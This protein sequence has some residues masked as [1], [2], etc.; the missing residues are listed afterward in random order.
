MSADTYRSRFNAAVWKEYRK[1]WSGYRRLVTFFGLLGTAVPQ[2]QRGTHSVAEAMKGG[3]IGLFLSVLGTYLYSRRKGAEAL[4]AEHLQRI[5]ELEKT[6]IELRA[7][8]EAAK[9]NP[10]AE[11]LYQETKLHV[12]KL[13]DDGR[14]VLKCLLLHDTLA[15]GSYNPPIELPLPPERFQEILR[16]AVGYDLLPLET[17]AAIL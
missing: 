17:T 9:R 8:V 1:F 16:H 13:G 14:K 3:A 5:P 7:Q 6:I 10:G 11:R 2:L 15:F 12:E 4:D